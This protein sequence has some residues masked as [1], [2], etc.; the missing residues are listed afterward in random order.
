MK[1]RIIRC[2]SSSSSSSSSSTLTSLDTIV[3]IV[4]FMLQ[5]LCLGTLSVLNSR[6]HAHAFSVS[7]EIKFNDRLKKLVS[8]G[9]LHQARSKRNGERD[10]SRYN[11]RRSEMN[12]A[13]YAESVLMQALAEYDASRL[14]ENVGKLA[15]RPNHFSFGIIISGYAKIGDWEGAESILLKMEHLY[16]DGNHNWLKPDVVKYTNVIKALARSLQQRKSINIS[17]KKKS[18]KVVKR[19]ESLLE[20]MESSRDPHQFPNTLTYS[21]MID[22]YAKTGNAK[23]ALGILDKMELSERSGHSNV[24]PNEIT[25]NACLNALAKGGESDGPEQAKKLLRRM[26]IAYKQGNRHV[27]PSIITYST[28]MGLYARYKKPFEAENILL[29]ALGKYKNGENNE[30]PDCVMYNT[31]ISAWSKSSH[32]DAPLRAEK[33]VK[34]MIDEGYPNP[35]T[36]TY[37][38]LI[39]AWSRSYINSDGS[40]IGASRAEEILSKMEHE[41]MRDRDT[42]IKPDSRTYTSLIDALAKSRHI[43]S[44]RKA[45]V[46]LRRMKRAFEVGNESAKPTKFSYSALVSTQKLSISAKIKLLFFN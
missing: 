35:N 4:S 41:F 10:R 39:D 21:A 27:K 28:V 37:N 30:Q 25:Y 13:Q 44:A 16:N 20:R 14:T 34:I 7:R 5:F 2:Q 9:N 43:G 42:C 12:G 3:P 31:A 46:I 33:L 45:E 36:V 15:M 24:K 40:S 19:A 23:K 22:L 6:Q 8:Q 18:E 17:S 38:S 29:D 32:Q 1:Y 11:D 26:E